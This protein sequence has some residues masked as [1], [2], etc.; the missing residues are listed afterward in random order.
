MDFNFTYRDSLC[1]DLRSVFERQPLV[2]AACP[3]CTTHLNRSEV[4]PSPLGRD[5]LASPFGPQLDPTRLYLCPNCEWWAIRESGWYIDVYCVFDYLITGTIKNFDLSPKRP[6]ISLLKDRVEGGTEIDTAG[7]AGVVAET[8]GRGGHPCEVYR[9]G[10][11]GVVEEG[12]SDVYLI[13]DEDSWIAQ[14]S[15][16]DELVIVN[17][18]QTLNGFLLRG[19]GVHGLA[20]RG[21]ARGDPG[22]KSTGRGELVRGPFCVKALNPERVPWLIEQ[23]PLTHAAPWQKALDGEVCCD[24]LQE[25]SKEFA[26]LLFLETVDWLTLEADHQV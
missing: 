18:I 11:C 3:M 13:E 21:E 2:L 12:Q 4:P 24:E 6:L 22:S 14:V 23:D 19:G 9:I 26:S 20:L 25:M 1:F 7:C 17:P 10:A 5:H 8:L 16:I 15:R